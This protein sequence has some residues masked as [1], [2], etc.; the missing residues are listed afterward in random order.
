MN[1]G[2]ETWQMWL[3][4]FMP[5]AAQQNNFVQGLLEFMHSKSVLCT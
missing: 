3:F 1:S 2:D 4:A 5:G